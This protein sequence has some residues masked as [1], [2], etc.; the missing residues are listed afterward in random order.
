MCAT[1][2]CH[3][4]VCRLVDD[5]TPNMFVANMYGI[6][7]GRRP[8]TKRFIAQDTYRLK[9]M[10]VSISLVDGLDTHVRDTHVRQRTCMAYMLAVAH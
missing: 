2:V 5:A 3:E 7:V 8:F 1:H 10:C 4:H 6:H 9:D